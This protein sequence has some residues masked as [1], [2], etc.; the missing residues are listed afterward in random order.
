MVFESFEQFE[1][2]VINVTH[3]NHKLSPELHQ[4]VKDQFLLNMK[5]DGASFLM[6]IRVDLLQKKV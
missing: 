3:T 2:R 4:R 1:Q 5:E 6:P